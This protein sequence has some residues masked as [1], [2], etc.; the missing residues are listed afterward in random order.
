MIVR[1]AAGAARPGRPAV[2]L[3]AR[4]VRAVPARALVRS[5]VVVRAAARSPVIVGPAGAAVVVGS[6]RAP[7]IVAAAGWWGYTHGWFAR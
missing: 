6:A 1:A 5:A 2:I 4:F 3:A 7:V